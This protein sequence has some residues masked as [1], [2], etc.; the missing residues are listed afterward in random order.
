M[1]LR[2]KT[3]PEITQYIAEKGVKITAPA[4]RNFFAR[5]AEAKLPL[6]FRETSSPAPSPPEP[7]PPEPIP[8]DPYSTEPIA[9]PLTPNQRKLK[10]D[11]DLSDA[12]KAPEE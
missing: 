2:R 9:E 7:S 12:P 8:I 5:A 1:R 10:Y 3:W 11:H 4:V 6:G